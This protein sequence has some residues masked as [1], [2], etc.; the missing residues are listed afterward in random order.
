MTTFEKRPLR[1]V[2]YWQ[3]QMLRSRDFGD[4]NADT[5]QH[6]WWH[7]RA[8]H[9]AY[10]VYQGLTAVGVPSNDAP[11]AVHVDSGVGYDCYGRELFVESPQTVVLPVNVPPIPI[12]MALLIRYESEKGCEPAST[13]EICWSTDVSQVAGT[14]CFSWKRLDE[15]RFC[16]GVPLGQVIYD[17]RGGRKV[18]AT[19][20]APGTRAIARPAIAT[21]STLPGNTPWQPWVVS[22]PPDFTGT[23]GGGSAVGVQAAIDTSA[24]GFTRMPCYFAWLAGPLFNAETGQLLPDIFTSLAHESANGFTFRMWFPPPSGGGTIMMRVARARALM[25]SAGGV[26]V[27]GSVGEFMSFARQHRL[28]VQWMACE[29]PPKLAFVPIWRRYLN[30][31]VLSLLF[32]Q[33]RIMFS[34]IR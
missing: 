17:G 16:D 7:N 33:V 31:S 14:A 25:S 8:L 23:A 34:S 19:F 20:I 22:A 24:A 32:H 11:T 28:Y 30:A 6:R 10:G 13:E 2:R 15:V 3:G 27:I 21:G 29:M 12:T 26:Q 9:N 18:S 4:Q 1:R 5:A